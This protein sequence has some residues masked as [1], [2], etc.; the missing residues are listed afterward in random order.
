[1]IQSEEE[2]EYAMAR[3]D[4]LFCAD[5]GTDEGDELD[6]LLAEIKKYED[7]YHPVPEPCE[8]DKKEFKKENIKSVTHC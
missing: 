8:E 1:M 3:V 2:Y 5:A 6:L 4:E 7:K